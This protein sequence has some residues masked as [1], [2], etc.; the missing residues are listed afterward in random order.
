M[1]RLQGRP[2]VVSKVVEAV[3]FNFY[4]N[5]EV[6]A[7]SVKQITSPI[8]FDNLRNPVS[9][10]LYDPALGPIDQKGGCI[11]CGQAAVH[12]PGHF[13][14]IDLILP[15]YSP[16]VFKMLVR[17]LKCICVFC[18]HFKMHKDRVNVFATKLELI[19]QGRMVEAARV[20]LSKQDGEK[21]GI[22]L[23]D[24]DFDMI[25]EDISD[26]L[27]GESGHGRRSRWTSTQIS[28]ARDVISRF[29]EEMPKSKC[30]NCLASVPII[31]QSGV[32]K[33]FQEPLSNNFRANNIMLGISSEVSLR[34]PGKDVGSD[35][36]LGFDEEPDDAT[37]FDVLDTGAMEGHNGNDSLTQTPKKGKGK[38][39]GTKPIGV[40]L[41]KV[42][43]WSRKKFLTTSE[44]KEHMRKVWEKEE[45]IC[46]LVWGLGEK[47]WHSH[48]LKNL[49]KTG[50]SMFFVESI[51]VTPNRFRP[52]NMMDGKLIEHPQNIF[53]G[54]M[55]RANIVLTEFSR[56]KKGEDGSIQKLDI[57]MATRLWLNLQ[58]E[59][60][61]LLDSTTATGLSKDQGGGGVRQLLE[62]KEGLFRM[63]MMGKRVNYACRSV[64]SPDPYIAV[65]EI[66]IPP[67]FAT[68]LTYPERVTP[69]NV[70]SMR[71][72]VENGAHVHPGATHV[73]DE[74]GGVVNLANLPKFKRTA[75]AKTLL[76]TPGSV[77]GAATIN[78]GRAIGKT[79]YRHLRDGDVLLV[80]RQPT[81]HKPG[82]MAHQARVLKGEKTLRLHY[83]NCS[84]Y[85]ADFDG[86]EMNVHFPQEELGRAEAYEI[87]NADQQYV[88]PTSGDPIRGLI[89]DH[90]CSATLLTKRDT[91]LTREEYQQLVYSA[92]VSSNPTSFKS[93]KQTVLGVIDHDDSIMPLPPAILKPR[94]LWTGKQVLT[95]VFN[96]VTF[97]LPPFSLKAPIKVSGEYWGK[98]SG[99]LEIILNDNELLCGV[100]D[101]AQFGKYG[102]IHSFQE[103]Y[104]AQ[105][106]GR[107]LSVFSRLFTA[108]LQMHGFTCGIG[109]LL[110]VPKAEKQRR[111]KLHKTEKLGDGINAQYV[112]IN[113]N[114]VDVD[115]EEVKNKVEKK[116]QS[117][118]EVASARLD[119][120][121]TSA[122]N[123]ITSDI[124]NTIFPRGL[125]KPFPSNCLSLMTI[126]GAK[127]GLVNFTQ[128]SSL[129]GQ[130]ELE[131]K[132]VPRMVSGKTLPCFPPWD[133]SARAGG[134]I[135]DRFLTGL[136]PQE[137]Y[138]HCMAGRDG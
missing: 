26:E 76:S 101:K 32:G 51:L 126:T 22:S 69:W 50:S 25:A 111:H 89:Q 14:H 28:A 63:N 18:H 59:V 35:D 73:E 11:T 13:G 40:K 120:L 17:I 42:V 106:A 123:R 52:A 107:L 49:K 20:Q 38:K 96:F 74:Q 109:D 54:R 67:Y 10:G 115:M 37:E 6:H 118:G 24:D 127:G 122:L 21:E 88:V 46:S 15:V 114:A 48:T 70:E 2:E 119:M 41:D 84:T 58:N 8:L 137:Y 97:G 130:Q 102:I 19:A 55:L 131:G 57:T 82:V 85:N 61:A 91:F 27:V 43:A 71:D 47:G 79:V 116:I 86:D 125:L 12:C 134:F 103:L 95:T 64:I 108:Y 113:E 66:G 117:K 1:S 44:V 78:G 133:T 83:A 77:M 9:G 99:E 98:T 112:G 31:K 65:N 5:E 136:R 75:L 138:F 72:A 92:C 23:S 68:R 87:V 33:I 16:L 129:L 29:M 93:K 53:Y 7:I 90:I 121:M 81:L 45:H 80:N 132:R 56:G 124:N 36:E 105:S 104:G 94:P 110:L 30:E 100:I 60:C 3:G 128:I 34:A 4:T 39:G 62:K 135:G